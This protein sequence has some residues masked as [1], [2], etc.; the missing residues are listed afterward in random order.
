[1][2]LAIAV[3]ATFFTLF[4]TIWATALSIIAV[5]FISL[6]I[7]KLILAPLMALSH[8]FDR[9]LKETL[10]EINIPVATI[11]ANSAMLE[12]ELTTPKQLRQLKRITQSSKQ[13]LYL[14]KQLEY[15]IKKEFET[16]PKTSID[17]AQFLHERLDSYRTIY[18]HVHFT[19]DTQP[20]SINIDTFGLQKCIDNII[21]NSVK[22]AKEHPHIDI[23]LKEGILTI[24]DNGIGISH[25]EILLIFE[26]YYQGENSS[27]GGL[28]IGLSIV[29][30]FCDKNKIGF[31]ISSTLKEFTKVVLN[32]R[33]ITSK[34]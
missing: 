27:Q 1:M 16:P 32:F 29:K 3:T 30:E 21:A 24:K 22:Y 11:Q 7:T 25:D 33:N 9:L 34:E 4:H 15:S 28:G 19:I 14:H 5:L 31:N 26:R 23:T 10:H 13:L 2:A 6:M 18:S 12:K 20:L 8:Y 17:L